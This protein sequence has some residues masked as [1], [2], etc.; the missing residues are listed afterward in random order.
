[1]KSTYIK[2][3]SG[4]LVCLLLAGCGQ[5]EERPKEAEQEYIMLRAGAAQILNDMQIYEDADGDTENE[6]EEKAR[7]EREYQARFDAIERIEDIEA[8]NY[9]IME[10][11]IFPMVVNPSEWRNAP[12]FPPWRKITTVWRFFWLMQK[13]ML[14]LKP[15]S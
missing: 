11:Q 13:A 14:S 1:M 3:L 2:I 6:A 9:E 15:I 8:N 7:K 12:F 5:R 10:E 4:F